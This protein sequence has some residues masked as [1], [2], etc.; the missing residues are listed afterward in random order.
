MSPLAVLTPA[1]IGPA[2]FREMMALLAGNGPQR[3][4]VFDQF[5]VVVAA[6]FPSRPEERVQLD[7]LGN[8]PCQR[9][10]LSS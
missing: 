10:S 5:V 2:Y 9:G 3:C 1:L 8:V 7:R 4:Q 6:P